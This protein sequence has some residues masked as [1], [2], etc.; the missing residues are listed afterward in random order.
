MAKV[1]FMQLDTD[2]IHAT[3]KRLAVRLKRKRVEMIG[4]FSLMVDFAIDATS[5]DDEA[6]TGILTG[7][8]AVAELETA[9]EWDGESGAFVAAL[10]ALDVIEQLADGVRVQGM[11]RYAATWLKRQKDRHRAA[12]GRST[13]TEI[14]DESLRNR[15]DIAA[16][17]QRNPS[18]VAA[19]SLRETE[20][21]TE[22]NNCSRAPAAPTPSRAA[23]NPVPH[24]VETDRPSSPHPGAV[25][26]LE[27]IAAAWSE[28]QPTVM[29][30]DVPDTGRIGEVLQEADVAPG[31][32]I[33]GYRAFLADP[34]WHG[35]GW[36]WS[37]FRKQARKFIARATAP[38]A[39]KKAAR[40][41]APVR[42][43]SVDWSKEQN[44]V[45][46]EL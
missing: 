27:G 39:P 8:D 26:A 16:K 25:E 41:G 31:A 43:E 24:R 38:P 35:E 21:E 23:S 45:F 17:S 22:S 2:F 40:P 20:T 7:S 13:R 9:A 1:P 14:A 44:G 33:A 36:P 5:T 37:G 4:M 15:S 11:K 34:Y 19:K 30:P 3:A 10:I 46:D 28:L 42:A 18:D 12:L 32:L 29:R 6:P